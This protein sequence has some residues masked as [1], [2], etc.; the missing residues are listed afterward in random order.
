MEFLNEQYVGKTNELKEIEKLFDDVLKCFP[1]VKNPWDGK[2]N[3]TRITN[4]EDRKKIQQ[5]LITISDKVKKMF[6]F[7]EVYI[8]FG[9]SA[10]A[11]NAFTIFS[12]LAK[13]TTDFKK[14]ERLFDSSKGIRFAEPTRV[15]LVSMQGPLFLMEDMTGELLTAILLHEIGHNFYYYTGLALTSSVL[16]CL[17]ALM[18]TLIT[19]P[20]AFL[21]TVGMTI[22]SFVLGT[23]TIKGIMSKVAKMQQ[24]A[25]SKSTESA[26]MGLLCDNIMYIM[27]AVVAIQTL[28]F[29]L[30]SSVATLPLIPAQML[31]S[32]PV[33][34]I[35]S[36]LGG[37]TGQNEELFCDN[38]ATMYGYGKA[39]VVVQSKLNQM[40]IFGDNF[41]ISQIMA[42]MISHGD[43]LAAASL[44]T[45][46]DTITRIVAQY[47]YLERQAKRVKDPLKKKLLLADIAVVK[48]QVKIAEKSLTEDNIKKGKLFGGIV[49]SITA[50]SGG[51]MNYRLNNKKQ[52]K[53]GDYKQL[54]SN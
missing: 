41:I 26:N 18:Q 30:L 47:D 40:G 19:M 12:P 49:N 52:T 25:E 1:K 11:P 14:N 50:K 9:D 31:M 15:C 22:M 6:N 24:K 46:P 29:T 35:Q 38:F 51:N 45:H 21:K 10:I 16:G 23:N 4:P 5:G 8:G 33:N 7:K 17:T 37:N 54:Q 42:D 32:I 36:I 44:S 2:V 53:N 3:L 20:M 13:Y 43:A 39:T 48:K 34:L 28:P 27:N